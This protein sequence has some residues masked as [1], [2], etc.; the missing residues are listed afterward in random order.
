MD[1]YQPLIICAN[2]RINMRNKYFWLNSLFD[3]YWWALATMQTRQYHREHYKAEDAQK[4]TGW[5][6]TT[7]NCGI[8]LY[9]WSVYCAIDNNTSEQCYGLK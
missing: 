5:N 6:D 7:V 9:Y 1:A 2:T 4:Y 8:V 3:L